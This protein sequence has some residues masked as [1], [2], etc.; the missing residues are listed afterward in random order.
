LEKAQRRFETKD[1]KSKLKK[2]AI[3][4]ALMGAGAW[5]AEPEFFW[6]SPAAPTPLDAL[7]T[8]AVGELLCT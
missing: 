8:L 5:H 7:L 1:S 3:L 6:L 2:T 4:I